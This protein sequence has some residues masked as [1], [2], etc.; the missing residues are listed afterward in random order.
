MSDGGKKM[1]VACGVLK[2]LSGRRGIKREGAVRKSEFSCSV[3]ISTLLMEV[4]GHLLRKEDEK[5]HSPHNF[6]NTLKGLAF[7]TVKE[8]LNFI[9]FF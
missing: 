2:S 5:F 9:F 8:E 3:L 4:L 7:P 1:G 6:C